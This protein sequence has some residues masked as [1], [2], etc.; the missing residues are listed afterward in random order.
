[1][2]SVKQSGPP[3]ATMN[4]ENIQKLQIRDVSELDK[5]KGWQLLE[6]VLDRN[7][8]CDHF[9]DNSSYVSAIRKRF[10]KVIKLDGKD[11][12]PPITFD[13]EKAVIPVSKGSHFVNGEI[14]DL[15][16]KFLK[17]FYT[18]Y[19]TDNRQPLIDAYHEH[20]IFSLTC[21]FNP[22]MEYRQPNLGDYLK[23]SRNA[24]KI[25]GS[26]TEVARRMDQLLKRGR[27]VV[28]AQ[29]TALPKTTHDANSFVVDVNFVSNTLLSFSVNGLFKES[30]NKADKPPIRAFNRC[31]VAVP[32][33]GGVLLISDMLTITNATSEQ[34]Q[35]A[36][37]STGPTPSSSPVSSNPPALTSPSTSV[38][39]AVAPDMS[40][41][42]NL[43]ADRQQMVLSFSQQSGMN[44]MFSFRCLEDCAWDYSKAAEAFTNLNA[45]GKIPPEAF[46]K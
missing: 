10:P 12:P 29:L 5:V 22:A 2:I 36:F 43:P 14:Q 21:N 35:A 28:V 45:Q 30:D 41:L 15:V 26:E 32:A 17:E 13:V 8:L 1:M 20:A 19:D 11:L 16:V 6:L 24:L 37:K 40:T 3:Y 9:K 18:I 25:P 42:E 23:L 31:F 27:L 39:P 46:Q 38:T 34:T 4:E 44:P 7:P 33:Q